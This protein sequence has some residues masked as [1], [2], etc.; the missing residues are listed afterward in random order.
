MNKALILIF[1]LITATACSQTEEKKPMESPVGYNFNNPTIYKMPEE[2]LEIS[3]IAFRPGKKDTMYAIQDEEG[4]FFYWKNGNPKT[5]ASSYFGDDG[6][7]EDVAIT[8]IYSFVLRSDG[9]LFQFPLNEIRQDKIRSS[10]IWEDLLPAGEYESL[11][12]DVEKNE[13]YVLCK[14]CG[15]D[16]KQESVSGY[17]LGISGTGSLEL[18]RNFKMDTRDVSPSESQKKNKLRPSAFTFNKRTNE[19]FIVSSVNKL[20]IIAD[21]AWKVKQVV[22]LNPKLFPQPEGI[23]FDI[24]NN[25]YI[26]NEAGSTSAGTVLMFRAGQSGK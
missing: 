7:Y 14:N 12:A 4:K 19:W 17:V 6:D 1:S 24:D 9:T 11:Y 26:S 3:G 21:A 13:L 16:K 2:L 10:K 18:K 20:L 15:A 23:T 8:N 25:L 22:K 5:L